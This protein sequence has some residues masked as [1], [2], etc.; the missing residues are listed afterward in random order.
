M[1]NTQ[2]D[3]VKEAT[4]EQSKSSTTAKKTTQESTQTNKAK[5]TTNGQGKSSTTAKKTTQE[6]TQTNKAKAT[7]NGQS[8][9]STTT[10][11]TT[12]KTA[13]KPKT[14]AKAKKESTVKEVEQELSVEERI[15][16]EKSK[17][18]A[19]ATADSMLGPNPVVGIS[20]KGIIDT[21]QMLITQ[22]LQQPL[23]TWKH[24]TQFWNEMW[25]VATG[26][27]ELMPHKRDIR[28]A[29]N[30]WK[31]N[32]L[33]RRAMQTYFAVTKELSEWLSE[34]ELDRYDQERA[35]FII[36]LFTEAL[37]PSNYAA[38][39]SAL[40]RFIETGGMSAVKGMQ[41]MLSDMINNGGMPSQVDKSAFELGKNLA[42]SPG[43]VVYRTEIFELIQYQPATE[44]VYSRPTL[45]VPPQ[46]NKFYVFDLSPEKSLARFMIENGLQT[47]IVSWRNPQPEHRDWGFS[48]YVKAV[49]EAGD[50]VS[51]ITGSKDYNMMGAC[52]GGVTVTSMIGN[53]AAKNLDKVNSTTLT[54]SVLDTHT[55]GDNASPMGLFA[56]DDAIE[57]A[58]KASDRQGVLKG[59]DMAKIFSWMRPNDLIWNYWVNNYLHGNKPPAFDVLFWNADTTQLPAKFHGEL[60]ELFKQNPLVNGKKVKIFGMDIDIPK[61]KGDMYFVSGI[62]DHITPWEVCYQSSKL[63][64]GNVE[65]ILSNSGHIQSILNP[66]TN[67]KASYFYSKERPSNAK[68]WF[69][70]AKKQEGSW[71]THWVEWAKER[72]G[73]EKAAPKELGNK[74]HKPITNSPGTYVFE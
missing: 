41:N 47:F 6:N 68:Q 7:T 69:G 54:V 73:A 9:S 49:E 4:N 31:E 51:E 27:S 22:S 42:L 37:A 10:K 66:P 32:P 57:T 5:A 45:V 18:I 61:I 39:P 33:Y 11:K 53:M 21:M 52:S 24:T 35:R 72:S 71:W 50:V 1:E 56:T 8:K 59:D 28:F 30:T 3:K 19:N 15:L 17:K 74:K 20:R 65:F 25:K 70:T 62:T 55:H 13:P 43:A 40:K 63:F 36:S 46:I 2:A 16:A 12:Q 44:K 58:R 29:D 67:P 26:K 64:N 60:L 34:S 48:D 38:N 14:E 23:L